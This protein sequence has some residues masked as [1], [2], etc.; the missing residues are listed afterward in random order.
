[1]ETL[2]LEQIDKDVSNEEELEQKNDKFFDMIATNNNFLITKE[3]LVSL[4]ILE[5]NIVEK[6]SPICIKNGNVSCAKF[7]QFKDIESFKKEIF[8]DETSF[9]IFHFDLCITRDSKRTSIG[10][11]DDNDSVIFRYF[12]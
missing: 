12:E 4:G 3:Y 1:M 10:T 9:G 5:E 8:R 11:V 2:D 7:K 6:D